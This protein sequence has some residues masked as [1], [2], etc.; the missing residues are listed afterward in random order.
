MHSSRQAG[1]GTD[2]HCVIVVV[3]V[4]VCVATRTPSHSTKRKSSARSSRL[5]RRRRCW[6]T[7]STE[8]TPAR[9][10]QSYSTKGRESLRSGGIATTERPRGVQERREERRALEARGKERGERREREG[11]RG[12]VGQGGGRGIGVG[13]AGARHGGRLASGCV[14]AI[15]PACGVFCGDHL[16]LFVH[17]HRIALCP[18]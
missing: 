11:E 7:R 12:E 4:D 17:D 10:S 2:V 1:L 5:Y 8:C 3:V 13:W 6:Q 16:C 14:S 18:H 15:A 9:A